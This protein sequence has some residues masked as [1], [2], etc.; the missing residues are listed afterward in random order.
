MKK[1][2]RRL[3]AVILAFMMVALPQIPAAAETTSVFMSDAKICESLGMLI[4]EGNGLTNEYLAQT[5]TRIQ[6]ALLY[7][8]LKGLDKEAQAFTGTDNFSDANKAAW[9]AKIMA[10][11][12]AHPELGMIGEGE[13]RFSPDTSITAQGYYKILLEAL[14]Y[15]A[16]VDFRWEDTLSFAAT[17]GMNKAAFTQQFS[18][19]DVA[20]ATVEALKSTVKGDIDTLAGRLVKAGKWTDI[21]VQGLVTA[22]IPLANLTTDISVKSSSS[23]LV[24]FNAP[25]TDKSKVQVETK[26]NSG[27]T[28]PFS[29]AWNP[30]GTQIEISRLQKMIPG[31]Y[32][33]TVI[34][35]KTVIGSKT[36]TIEAE[37]LAKIEFSPKVVVRVSDIKGEV[38]YR[39]YN[40]YGEDISTSALVQNISW[41]SNADSISVDVKNSKLTV[42][43]DGTA[44]TSQL[45]DMKTIFVT[46]Y[47]SRWS[48]AIAEQLTVSDGFGLVKDIKFMGLWNKD[49]KTEITVDT[50]EKFYI[51]YEA[52][53]EFGNRIDNYS[54][55]SNLGTFALHSNNQNI[56]AHVVRDPD[57]L[58][59][60]LIEVDVHTEGGFADITG[61]AL[62]AGKSDTIRVEVK[63]GA[64][65]NEFILEAPT[66]AVAVNERVEI[67][68]R[69][70]DQ[71]GNSI[72]GYDQ[73]NGKIVIVNSDSSNASVV[74]ERSRDGK[75][76]L[77]AKFNAV[78]KYNIKVIVL[79][80]SKM[81]ELDI[82]AKT[83]AAPAAIA[84]IN[85]DVITGAIVENGKIYA[86]FVKN[87][88]FT[89][90]D[91][92]GNVF[93][94]KDMAM[95]GNYYYYVS[96]TPA[97][98]TK[99]NLENSSS[100]AC[101]DKEIVLTGGTTKGPTKITF[102]LCRDMDL[103]PL[104]GKEVLDVKEVSITNVD[105]KDIVEYGIMPIQALYANPEVLQNDTYKSVSEQKQ[106]YA[107]D[108][109]VFGKLSNGEK[110]ALNPVIGQGNNILMLTV[111]D[112]SKFNVDIDTRKILAKSIGT[113]SEAV[114]KLTAT[115]QGAGGMIQTVSVEIKSS[116]AVPI[117]QSVDVVLKA[118]SQIFRSGDSFICTAQ[119][120]N[121]EIAGR[122]LRKYGI[123]GHDRFGAGITFVVKDQY[124]NRGLSPSYF[125]V[126]RTQGS[127]S[128]NVEPATGVVTGLAK[129]GDQYVITGVTNNGLTK[130]ITINIQ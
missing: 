57:N 78:R 116:K 4:G 123:A 13:N 33:V 72:T 122:E 75:F 80:S 5:P 34:Y 111:T 73:I 67:P 36:I 20:T 51:R 102:E 107:V 43:K 12:K 100:V 119:V 55:L 14:G 26:L 86:D 82:E 23:F 70:L 41:T 125:A 130:E 101:K 35:D 74:G 104:N 71:N 92:N 84:A 54:I 66:Q 21:Q 114:D 91:Q 31:S 24:K 9:A 83:A 89:V 8:R 69:A 76:V 96:A 1:I 60:A 63:K 16:G 97:D 30:E 59:K 61:V 117:P 115:V 64:V 99:V 39:A 124:G 15:K 22:G 7:L 27:A 98:R 46:A 105:R 18:V 50:P 10:Y 49:G 87:P 127:G 6:A 79:E 120:F 106:Q 81:T 17:K 44:G 88:A 110:V 90:H 112:P 56:A 62:S 2:G 94:M 45:K 85:R 77:A 129:S 118:E 38:V 103:N 58:S 42:I 68:Y 32:T 25:V 121:N 52:K 37:K 3:L 11:L 128:V 19:N 109:T 95:V 126:T 53:D 113:E 108:I 65:V 29:M 40:Q 48:T 28:E 93:N 47:D